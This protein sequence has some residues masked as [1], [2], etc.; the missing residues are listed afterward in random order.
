M[1]ADW[2]VL[3]IPAR[4]GQRQQQLMS[5]PSR[6]CSLWTGY[7][8]RTASRPGRL[9]QLLHASSS[10]TP[11]ACNPGAPADKALTEVQGELF[12][13]D[14]PAGSTKF[15]NCNNFV[16]ASLQ[17]APGVPGVHNLVFNL[18]VKGKSNTTMTVTRIP[19]PPLLTGGTS[20]QQAAAASLQ[21]DQF[22]AVHKSKLAK[23]MPCI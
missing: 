12:K 13:D 15:A 17:A 8:L 1:Y 21:M 18:W 5:A 10:A 4:V 11:K 22:K 23:C 3:C 7:S 6:K 14:P 16:E 20:E 9:V 2:P 19:V